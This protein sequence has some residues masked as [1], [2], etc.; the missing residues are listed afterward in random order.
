MNGNDATPTAWPKK[1]DQQQHN[2]QR[3]V[4]PGDTAPGKEG[5]KELQ[6]NLR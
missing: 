5:S 6:K 1:T 4:Q 2:S 3:I